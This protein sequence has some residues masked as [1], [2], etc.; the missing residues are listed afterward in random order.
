MRA[1][2]DPAQESFDPN[3]SPAPMLQA[4]QKLAED[5]G[6]SLQAMN[7]RS[8]AEIGELA[9]RTYDAEK[10]PSFWQIWKDWHTPRPEP[11]MGDL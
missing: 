6:Q 8:F 9:E 11:E 2:Y 10:M 3:D 7:G 1:D 4:V 5:S